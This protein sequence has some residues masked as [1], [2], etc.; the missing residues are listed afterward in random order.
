MR[1]KNTRIDRKVGNGKRIKTKPVR[2]LFT[3]HTK[4]NFYKRR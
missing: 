2:K 3:P 4:N 1:K